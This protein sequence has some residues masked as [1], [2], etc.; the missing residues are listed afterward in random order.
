MNKKY[1]SNVFKLWYKSIYGCVLNGPIA[2][3]CLIDPVA[4]HVS[5]GNNKGVIL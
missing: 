5:T 3:S 1:C 2:I 4:Y